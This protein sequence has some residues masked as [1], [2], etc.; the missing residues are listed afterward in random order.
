MR[1]FGGGFAGGGSTGCLVGAVN[2]FGGGTVSFVAAVAVA[3][4]GAALCSEAQSDSCY[5]IW[6]KVK[7]V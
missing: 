5:H 4:S 3:G 1:T 7:A 6:S 2:F